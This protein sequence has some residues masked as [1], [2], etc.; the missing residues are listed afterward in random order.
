MKEGVWARP[1]HE[2]TDDRWVVMSADIKADRTKSVDV[3][4]WLV[5]VSA[6]DGKPVRKLLLRACPSVS[7]G[8]G[9]PNTCKH[10]VR[11]DRPGTYVVAVATQPP[12]TRFTYQMWQDRPGVQGNR[13]VW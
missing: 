9:A 2:L 5:E 1:C 8:P 12:G 4:V 3:Y 10:T 7:V 6:S 13:F 11:P